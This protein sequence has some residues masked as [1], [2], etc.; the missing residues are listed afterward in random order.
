MSAVSV[1]VFYGLQCGDTV[2]TQDTLMSRG[3]FF[4]D[5]LAELLP[6]TPAKYVLSSSGFLFLI[7]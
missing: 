4:K 5:I 7:F 1:N 6:V 2:K 3:V